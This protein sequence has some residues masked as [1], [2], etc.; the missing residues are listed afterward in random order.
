MSRLLVTGGLG[1]VGSFA[2][3]AMKRAGHEVTVFDDASTGRRDAVPGIP[4]VIGDCRDRA[5]LSGVLSHGR[6]EA[7]LHFAGL[8]Q[9]GASVRDPVAYHAANVG[10]AL[11]LL[12]AMREAGADRI[13]F[14]SSAAVYG[15][16]ASQPIPEDAPIAPVNPYGRSKAAVEAVLRDAAA[17]GQVRAACL[18]YFNAAGASADGRFGEAHDPET[19]LIPRLLAAALAGREVPVYGTDYPTPDGTAVRDYVHVEDLADAHARALGAL[20]RHPF[21]AL[22]LGTG[23]GHSVR[24][25]VQAAGRLLGRP[26]PVREA[27][28]REGDPAMLVAKVT[29]A[30]SL[31]SWTPSCSDLDHILKT[32][33]QWHSSAN[34]RIAS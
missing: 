12:E 15:A 23:K 19:H 30:R 26:V 18:R 17:A 22:N 32:S 29:Q 9:V 24:E 1:Y 13:V 2:A 3:R 28:R 4:V 10:G 14:S 27:P 34:R 8:S 33:I 31:L 21:L 16:P 6:I 11:A 25:V 20:D 5:T 7:V